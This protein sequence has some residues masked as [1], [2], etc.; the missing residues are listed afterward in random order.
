MKAVVISFLIFA[1]SMLIM[2]PSFNMGTEFIPAELVKILPFFLIGFA[3][4]CQW[5][6]LFD[7][8]NTLALRKAVLEKTT[9]CEKLKTEFA[10]M[11]NELAGKAALIEERAQE[12]KILKDTHK[13]LSGSSELLRQ[14]NSVF[15]T[16][17]QEA[18][19]TL[20]ETES[21]LQ[22]SLEESTRFKNQSSHSD[23]L[24]LLSL[25]QEKGRLLDFLMDDI[26]LYSDAQVG[27]AGRVVHQGCSKVL[28]EFFNV[29]PLH[30]DDEGTVINLRKEDSILAYR[31]L[32]RSFDQTPFDAR[33][34][35]RGWGTDKVNVPRRS[36][37]PNT[38]SNK[39]VI[40]PVEVEA[41]SLQS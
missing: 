8:K 6:A 19:S 13:S 10:S 24:T 17:L 23:V 18:Q 32:G 7:Y 40:S 35:H 41:Y 15:K 33:I 3:M 28:S 16:K 39:F 30:T 26:T 29:S 20:S 1:A 27:A 37:A 12:Y 36:L 11:K 34:L 38:L 4:L 9:E 31:V 25:F 2:L 14:E 22:A 5:N 21:K